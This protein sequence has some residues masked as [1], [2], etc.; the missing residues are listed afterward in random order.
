MTKQISTLKK[1]K[2]IFSVE[3]VV[4]AI[5]KAHG[6][7]SQAARLLGCNRQ[8]ITN[9]IDRHEV[10]KA[11]FEDAKESFV[12]MAE[13]KLFEN[14]EKGDV[15]SIIFCLKTLGK[16]RGYLESAKI[17]AT[18]R[19]TGWESIKIFDIEGLNGDVI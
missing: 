14:I 5:E 19:P 6:I 8:T 16:D 18:I 17:S 12:D 7:K 13:S 9:Y 10:I 4:V 15:T 1:S 2:E 11:A 3:Q